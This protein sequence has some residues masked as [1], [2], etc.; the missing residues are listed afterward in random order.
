MIVLGIDPGTAVTGYG[1]VQTNASNQFSCVKY[2]TFRTHAA[3]SLTQRLKTIYDGVNEIIA[4]YHPDH[5]A[6]EDIFYGRNVQAALKLGQVRGVVITAAL[7]A[8]MPIITLAAR[9]V[10]QA[11]TGSGAAS[12]QQVQCM[13]KDLLGL[14]ETASPLD[15]SDALAIALCH[16]QRW[17][18]SKKRVV[19][20]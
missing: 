20:L 14:T 13:V 11:L 16:A 10:K 5:I 6:I 19:R 3:E 15:A 8:D 9:E 4:T 12:K 7:N 18:T 2:G 1:L 17:W